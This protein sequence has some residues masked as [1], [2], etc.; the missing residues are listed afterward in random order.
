[1][2]DNQ[3]KQGFFLTL[4]VLKH[5]AY[6]T[7]NNNVDRKNC[8]TKASKKNGNSACCPIEVVCCD[9]TRF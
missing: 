4:P 6:I 7:S 8:Q 5:I 1:M 3:M 9:D 2:N